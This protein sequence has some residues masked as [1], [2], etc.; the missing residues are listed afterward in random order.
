[1]KSPNKTSSSRNSTLTTG[2]LWDFF[3]LRGQGPEKVFI[4][5]VL[6]V[7]YKFQYD[8]HKTNNFS[9]KFNP[10]SGRSSDDIIIHTTTVGSLVVCTVQEFSPHSANMNPFRVYEQMLSIEVRSS[11]WRDFSHLSPASPLLRV[12]YVS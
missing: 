7:E 3:W 8:W 5:V 6:C 1:V 10:D 12:K 2:Y 4:F 9:L 11:C